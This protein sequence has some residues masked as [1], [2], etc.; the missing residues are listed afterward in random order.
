MIHFIHVVLFP[1]Y[2]LTN[3]TMYRNFPLIPLKDV[4]FTKPSV[5]FSLINVTYHIYRHNIASTELH[6]F[7][8]CSI[9]YNDGLSALA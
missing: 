1:A 4:L 7:N 2:R 8:P 9:W 6:L 5:L 3:D